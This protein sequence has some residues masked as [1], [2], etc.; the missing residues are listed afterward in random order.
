MPHKIFDKSVLILDESRARKNIESMAKKASESDTV[1]RPHFKT[2][3]SIEIGGW[4]KEVGVSGITVSSIQMAEYFA[5]E[6]WE[7]ITIAFPVSYLQADRLSR[8]ASLTELRILVVDHETVLN[9]DNA[10]SSELQAYIELDPGYQR[11]GIPIN[12]YSE[13]EALKKTIQETKN[14]AFH[15]FYTH[16][17]HSYKCRSESEVLEL[18]SPISSKLLR[19]KK[20]F[21]E[22]VCFGDTPSCSLLESFN[23][24]DELS[25]GNFVFYDWTQVEIGSCSPDKIAVVMHCPI[26]AKYPDRNEFLIHGGAIHFSKD[27]FTDTDGN[28]FFG[29]IVEQTESGFGSPID[30]SFVKSLS[31]EHGIVRCSDEYFNSK[32]VG[33]FVSILPIHSCLTAESMGSYFT[34]D[35]QQIDHM[36]KKI[37]D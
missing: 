21:K 10:L 32:K 37:N 33:D 13:I 8:I 6:G 27:S 34:F 30:G 20:E 12:N 14:I 18:V 16:S 24:A 5:K 22:P 3:Q 29:K 26:V 25:P 9:L 17:G 36:S 11:S 2:H 15:G 35:G 19:F 1:F 4:F 28:T 31:Q 23:F 7:S